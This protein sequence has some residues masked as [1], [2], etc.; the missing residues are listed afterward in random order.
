M[1]CGLHPLRKAAGGSMVLSIPLINFGD[2]AS[3]NESKAWNKH[4][5]IYC[6][7][8][9]L[10]REQMQKETNVHFVGSSPVASSA[11]MFQG[12]RSQI[13]YAALLFNWYDCPL[14]E[15]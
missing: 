11:E 10:P 6:N 9:A 1:V 8:A 15:R 5:N 12:V 2:D 13:K 7:N 4:I 14:T 3:G